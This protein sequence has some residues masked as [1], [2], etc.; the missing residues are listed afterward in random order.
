VSFATE[1]LDAVVSRIEVR[2]AWAPTITIDRPFSPSTP[3]GAGDTI[4]KLMRPEIVVFDSTGAVVIER[5][6]FGT[7]GPSRWPIVAALAILGGAVVLGLAL[8]R[9][10]S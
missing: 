6:P 9:I 2:S 10:R 3:G 5:A 1:A 8:R 4:G 7:P